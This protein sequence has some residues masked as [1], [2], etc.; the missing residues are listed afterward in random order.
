MKKFLHTLPL[1]G[2]LVGEKWS[3]PAA[4]AIRSR[5]P[6]ASFAK[7]SGLRISQNDQII[8]AN[9]LPL[10]AKF[11]Q[12][13]QLPWLRGTTGWCWFG[14]IHH[15]WLL[16]SLFNWFL[17][18]HS[19]ESLGFLTQEVWRIVNIF[20][21]IMVFI[22]LGHRGIFRVE[23]KVFSRRC[24]EASWVSATFCLCLDRCNQFR[25]WLLFYYKIGWL[26]IDSHIVDLLVGWLVSLVVA[27]MVSSLKGLLVAWFIH[28]KREL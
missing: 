4:T 11:R 27:S 13:D 21:K 23:S 28:R 17:L 22:A 10:K 8:T 16:P 26:D 6:A 1:V 5:P 3:R 19:F 18:Y 9:H 24:H 25:L 15:W 20:G 14:Q 12:H 7:L 2:W